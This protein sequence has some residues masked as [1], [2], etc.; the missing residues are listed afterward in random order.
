[1]RNHPAFKRLLADLDAK[2][3]T[4]SSALT[5]KEADLQKTMYP[6]TS[7]ALPPKEYLTA[8]LAKRGLAV[9]DEERKRDARLAAMQ[10]A[11]A[12]LGHVTVVSEGQ[13]CWRV[14]FEDGV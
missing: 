14:L 13:G 2:G 3:T 9:V 6:E 10:T 11:L 1:M 8:A 7:G 12:A 4:L 5:A